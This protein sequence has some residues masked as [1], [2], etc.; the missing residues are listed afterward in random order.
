MA[1]IAIPKAGVQKQITP[2]YCHILIKGKI[3]HI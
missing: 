2:V 1:K 3:K